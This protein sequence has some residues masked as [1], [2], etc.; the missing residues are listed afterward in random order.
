MV[1]VAKTKKARRLQ[2]SPTRLR[3]Q[4]ER[5]DSAVSL[6]RLLRCYLRL[7]L[8]GD[9]AQGSKRLLNRTVGADGSEFG[10]R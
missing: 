2:G 6:S 1:C 7:L 8:S 3:K 4:I 5:R 10:A 9:R